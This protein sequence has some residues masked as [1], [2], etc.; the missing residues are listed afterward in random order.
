M[1]RLQIHSFI[2]S[3]RKTGGRISTVTGRLQKVTCFK[4]TTEGSFP[5][6]LNKP[7]LKSLFS[8]RLSI[9]RRR[10]NGGLVLCDRWSR[11]FLSDFVAEFKKKKTKDPC[12]LKQHGRQTLG[13]NRDSG[14]D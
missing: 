7:C 5:A 10:K 3:G 11:H 14:H 6:Y 2:I 9:N 4:N 1:D 8:E 13:L 12:K